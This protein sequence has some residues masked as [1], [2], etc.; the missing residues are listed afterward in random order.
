MLTLLKQARAFGLGVVLA[1]QNPVDLDYKGLS[2]TG[3]WFL[4]RLQTERDKA[5][6]L[7]GLEGASASAG[8]SFDKAAME[9]TLAGLGSRVFLVNNVHEDAPVLFHTR[10]AMSYLRGPLTR[11]QIQQLTAERR[12]AH[13]APVPPAPAVTP[14]APARTVTAPGPEPVERPVV[15]PGVEEVFLTRTEPLRTGERLRYR[16]ALVASARLHFTKART[17]VD[18]WRE[19]HRLAFLDEDSVSDPWEGAAI[20]AARPDEDPEPESGGGFA[21]AAPPVLRAASYK[22]WSKQLISEM[23]RNRRVT[24]WTSADPKAMS[25]SGE[26]R[27]EFLGRLSLLLREERD[28]DLA[29]LEERYRPKLARIQ[30][31]IDRARRRLEKEEDQF[32]Q[33]S[34]Q[35]AVDIGASVLGALLGRKTRSR[36]ASAARKAGRAAG[37]RGDIGR[38]KEELASQREA[39]AAL[40]TEF[41]EAASELRVPPR[42]EDLELTEVP[43]KPRKSDLEVDTLRLAWVPCRAE[44]DGSL[45]PLVDLPA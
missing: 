22:R 5:R 38:A 17:D 31:R 24:L 2:N 29:K 19:E 44:A 27:E 23:Y 41:R 39:L 18:E 15:P 20:L 8:A 32:R 14:A 6:V 36:G 12:A 26:S 45:T 13:P 28:R 10:W 7:E 37:E 4:G 43:I 11:T 42:P 40:E 25:T 1:T 16:P 21:E 33:Q 30:E 9:R 34:Y 3:T 35:A